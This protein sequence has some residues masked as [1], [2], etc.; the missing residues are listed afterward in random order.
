MTIVLLAVIRRQGLLELM[1][2]D[3]QTAW[4]GTLLV[5]TLVP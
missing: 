3:E 4:T 2:V 5:P 1:R